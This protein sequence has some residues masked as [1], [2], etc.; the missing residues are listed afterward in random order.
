MLDSLFNVLSL[1][2]IPP[3]L[4]LLVRTVTATA[5]RLGITTYPQGAGVRS[6]GVQFVVEGMHSP[7]SLCEDGAFKKLR[8]AGRQN[9]SA[10]CLSACC[11]L[12]FAVS[13]WRANGP[14][15]VLTHT[16]CHS[17]ASFHYISFSKL[18]LAVKCGSRSL[19]SQVNCGRKGR[20]RT[21]DSEQGSTHRV[22]FNINMDTTRHDEASGIRSQ[23]YRGELSGSLIAFGAF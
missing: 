19:T 17:A 1:S 5:L 8:P 18:L 2:E 22:T 21:L 20:T 7:E 3:G 12:Y 9:V 13:T 16:T 23:C 10:A 11:C 6:L 14:G 15:D 4:S